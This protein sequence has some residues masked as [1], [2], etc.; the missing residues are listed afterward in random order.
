MI[1][2]ERWLWSDFVGVLRDQPLSTTLPAHADLV[3]GTSRDRVCAAAPMSVSTPILASC[4]LR[5]P[6]ITEKCV[7]VPMYCATLP[8]AGGTLGG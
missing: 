6:C 3:T 4:G 2:H 5:S 1:D 7:F 8:K